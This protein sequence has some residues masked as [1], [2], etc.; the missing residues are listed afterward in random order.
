M[1]QGESGNGVEVYAYEDAPQGADLEWGPLETVDRVDPG[2]NRGLTQEQIN[3]MSPADVV[4][5]WANGKGGHIDF[6]PDSKMA[7]IFSQGDGAKYFENS[8]L[9][10]H[11]PQPGAGLLVDKFPYTFTWS[12][13]FSTINSAEHVV[14]SWNS[15]TAISD[16]SSIT[17]TV[18]NRMG[19]NSL[20]FGR[21]LHEY[22]GIETVGKTASDL[23]MSISW[24]RNF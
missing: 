17:Y 22:F 18:H 8:V 16:G 14:G 21:Q 23:T 19:A 6:G 3:N 12:R 15:G 2:T 7:Q 20:M 24:K 5:Y 1:P 4:L 9:A 11:G 13:A 10:E